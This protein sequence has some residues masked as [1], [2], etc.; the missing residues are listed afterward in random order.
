MQK[1]FMEG[2]PR[3]TVRSYHSTWECWHSVGSFQ[4]ANLQGILLAQ[5]IT[6]HGGINISEGFWEG[7]SSTAFLLPPFLS[8]L[9]PWE[10]LPDPHT[11]H[12]FWRKYCDS[13]SGG[14]TGKLGWLLRTA[15]SLMEI[16]LS[17]TS[18]VFSTV[19]WR[20]GEDLMK[21]SMSTAEHRPSILVTAYVR[22]VPV[23]QPGFAAFLHSRL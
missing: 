20:F 19:K 23:S 13:Y 4:P 22:R 11:S 21:Q 14:K 3:G 18:K 2:R 10:M 12:G 1:C 16:L 15:P 5:R 7:N 6:G 8:C 17:D 9:T